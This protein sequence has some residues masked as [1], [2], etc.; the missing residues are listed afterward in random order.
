MKET[1]AYPLLAITTI[2]ALGLG[3]SAQAKFYLW[4]TPVP[5]TLQVLI[6]LLL[7]MLSERKIAV[8]T[9]I[10]YVLMGMAGLP[11]FAGGASG[12]AYLLGPTGGYIV[13]FLVAVILMTSCRDWIYKNKESNLGLFILFAL[14]VMGT[15]VI[16]ACGCIGLAVWMSTVDNMSLEMCIRPAFQA[17]V[18]PFVWFDMIKVFFAALIGQASFALKRIR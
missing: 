13:G 17:G 9:V 2:G 11:L 7:A 16:Y 10:Q 6:V 14:G 4:F 1:K 3:L 12:L 8:M 5:I 15:A 18:V